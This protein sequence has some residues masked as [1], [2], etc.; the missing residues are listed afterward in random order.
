MYRQAKKK[1]RKDLLDLLK[2]DFNK[3]YYI[4]TIYNLL[5]SN[6]KTYNNILT[7]YEKKYDI[8]PWQYY[9]KIR[10]FIKLNILEENENLYKGEKIDTLII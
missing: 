9:I 3:S 5:S 6:M 1:F 10:S 4:T 2:L 7:Y 8:R